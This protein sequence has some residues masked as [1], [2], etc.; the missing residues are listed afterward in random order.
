[1]MNEPV[2]RPAAAGPID[3]GHRDHRV[4]EHVP[5]DHDLLTQ[6]LAPRGA[7]VVLAD[8]LEH[9]R[10]R[11][12]REERRGTESEDHRRHHHVLRSSPPRDREQM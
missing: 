7:H 5:D 12:A 4:L 9:R 11:D 1:M 10:A 3:R 6:A 8:R 2:M